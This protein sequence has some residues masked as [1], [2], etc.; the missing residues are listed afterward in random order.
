M[1]HHLVGAKSPTSKKKKKN[2]LLHKTSPHSVQNQSSSPS[3]TYTPP[4]PPP[5]TLTHLKECHH[6]HPT[7]PNL[8]RQPP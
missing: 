8:D 2:L 1:L 5:Y 4:Y 3:P 6:P 7:P